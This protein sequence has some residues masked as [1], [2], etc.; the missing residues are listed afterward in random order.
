MDDIDRTQWRKSSYSGS[1]GG[2]CVEVAT[3]SD[4]G[5]AVRDSKDTAGP[6]LQLFSLSGCA[7]A[8]VTAVRM[9]CTGRAALSARSELLKAGELDLI[10]GEE[11]DYKFVNES[12]KVSHPAVLS[13]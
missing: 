8:T 11:I 7:R 1:N 4:G 2:A 12:R 3:L 5:R 10:L 9:P 13:N 6:A